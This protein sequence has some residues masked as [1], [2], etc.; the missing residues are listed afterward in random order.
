LFTEAKSSSEKT[1]I[2]RGQPDKDER[3]LRDGVELWSHASNEELHEL[4]LQADHI[5]CRSG[6]STLMDLVTLGVKAE[7]IPTPGQT[8]QEYLAQRMHALHGWTFR[9]QSR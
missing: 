5:T 6:Y 1:L 8:E 2:V 4:L 3:T 9:V 7:L